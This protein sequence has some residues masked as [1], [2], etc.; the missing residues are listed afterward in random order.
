MFLFESIVDNL[1]VSAKDFNVRI[2]T[3]R[4]GG[5]E[6]CSIRFNTRAHQPVTR[7]PHPATHFTFS[8]STSIRPTKIPRPAV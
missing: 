8:K 2:T 5:L 1:F 7:N 3:F 6:Y 4:S